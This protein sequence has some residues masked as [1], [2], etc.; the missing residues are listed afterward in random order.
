M[1]K[2]PFPSPLTDFLCR[3]YCI[4]NS[5]D[6]Q[7]VKGKIVV[8]ELLD[9]GIGPFIAGA[10]G[11]VTGEKDMGSKDSVQ[12]FPL[13]TSYLSADDANAISIYS[14]SAR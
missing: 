3:R 9:T 8:C 13:P 1:R 7:S 6:P 2:S 10:A 12:S 4:E 5:L 11:Y 14:R